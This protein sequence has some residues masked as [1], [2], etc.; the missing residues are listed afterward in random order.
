[1]FSSGAPKKWDESVIFEILLG[2]CKLSSKK[3]AI[4]YR[5]VCLVLHVVNC[6]CDL[7]MQGEDRVYHSPADGSAPPVKDV[8]SC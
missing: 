2:K 4:Q 5:F 6:L 1:M 3:V 7:L 8:H